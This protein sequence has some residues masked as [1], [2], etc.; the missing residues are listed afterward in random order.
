MYFHKIN[1]LSV[2]FLFLF[3]GFASAQNEEEVLLGAAKTSQAGIAQITLPE[4]QKYLTDE[5]GNINFSPDGY[6]LITGGTGGL[7]LATTRWMIEKGARNLVLC[8]RRGAE[9]VSPEILAN[10]SSSGA[11]ITLK[12]LDI[13]DAEKL[14]TVLEECRSKYPVRGVFNISGT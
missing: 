8:S 7:G 9:G 2:L 14:H 11:E 12:K 1:F 10:L 3:S 6:Y 5:D 13:T 4:N